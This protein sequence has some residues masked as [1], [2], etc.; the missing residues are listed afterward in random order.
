MR[1]ATERRSP[2]TIATW[3]TPSARSRWTIRPASGR[4]SSAIT[5]TPATAPS[6]PTS[7]CASPDPWP[8]RPRTGD[9][10]EPVALGAQEGPA[11]D[12]NAMAVDAAGDALSRLLAHVDRHR[13]LQPR[14]AGGAHQRLAEDVRRQPVDRGR[15][16]QHLA[17][18]V[19]PTR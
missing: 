12:G 11:A 1:L 7:T 13:Q 8:V 2:E 9:L 5:I 3:R 6:M 4:S 19:P 18:A 16:T 14:L 15:E 10:V 17:G